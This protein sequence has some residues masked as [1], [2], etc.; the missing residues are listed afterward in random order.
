LP[1]APGVRNF[2]ALR[3]VIVNEGCLSVLN[4]RRSTAPPLRLVRSSTLPQGCRNCEGDEN[5]NMIVRQGTE[6]ARTTYSPP[7]LLRERI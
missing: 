5:L 6:P 2:A 7:V 4:I 3:A 1:A